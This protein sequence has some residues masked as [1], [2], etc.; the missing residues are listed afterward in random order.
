MASSIL[1]LPHPAD[2]WPDDRGK[3]R[4]LAREWNEFMTTMA[5]DNPGRF[6]VFAALPI[7]DIDGS[8]KEIEYALDTLG[9]DGVAL[10]TNIGDRWLGDTHYTPV[11]E[12]LH[13]HMPA[14]LNAALNRPA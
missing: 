8:L 5:H 12:E 10:M 7:L 1:S 11:F 13:R 3:G 14:S 9:A 4:L 6:G 2:T